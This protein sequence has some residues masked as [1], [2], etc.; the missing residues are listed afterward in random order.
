[1]S[2]HTGAASTPPSEPPDRPPL[3]VHALQTGRVAVHQSQ[4]RGTGTGNA[5][6]LRVLRDKSWT[7][8]LPIHAWAIEHPEGL[9]VVDTG[10]ISAAS[11]PRHYPALNP[12]LRRATRFDIDRQD[13][14][15]RQLQQVGLAVGQVRWVVITHLHTD[16]AG[17]L[18]YFRDAEI[19]LTR[20]EWVS[21]QGLRG[22][23]RGYLPQYFPAWLTPRTV[24]FRAN[25]LG[26]FPASYPL[27]EAGDVVLVPTPGHTYGHLS[28]IVDQPGGP[29]LVLAGD[30]SYRQDLMLEGAVDGVAADERAAIETLSRL[31]SYAREQPTIYLPA[32]DPGSGKRFAA[33]QTVPA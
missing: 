24:D 21:A 19:V 6:R 16:H 26:P 2:D 10:E 29:R 28:V 31:R 9:I 15:D 32:H 3:R 12:Y 25:P 8:P 7:G 27:T 18:G 4:V 1:M 17:G 13:E 30:A 20:K 5:R 22:R 14:I 23:G 33:K 11:D